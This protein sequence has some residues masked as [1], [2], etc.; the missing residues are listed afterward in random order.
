MERWEV[1]G[2][3]EA[4]T[5]TFAARRYWGSVLV[6]TLADWIFAADVT[7]T[8]GGGL[9]NRIR[10]SVRPAGATVCHERHELLATSFVFI[11]T[12]GHGAPWSRDI[13]RHFLT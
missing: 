11:N 1:V 3:L 6:V 2:P 7:A 8:A 9:R 12:E 13:R 10:A 4:V 5:R